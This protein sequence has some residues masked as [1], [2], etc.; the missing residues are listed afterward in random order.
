MAIFGVSHE[1]FESFK[2]S[3]LSRISGIET[4]I[5]QR[6]ADAEQQARAAATNATELEAQVRSNA[7][8]VQSALNELNQYKIGAQK[9][10]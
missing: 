7:G 9:E 1:D 6:P 2:L 4:E 10:L 5:R 8:A 3:I